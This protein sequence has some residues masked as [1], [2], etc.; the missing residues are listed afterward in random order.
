MR[1][2]RLSLKNWRNFKTV[3]IPIADRLFV[4][5]PNAL[6]KSNLLDA[7][8]FLRDI[9]DTGGDLQHAVTVR[10]GL[11]RVRCLAA[12]NFNH[13]R[14]GLEISLHDPSSDTTWDYELNLTA[15][16][17][18]LHRPVVTSE[19]VREN[20]ETI[21]ERPVSED[22]DDRERLTQTALE[23]VNSNRRFRAVVEFLTG[24]CYLH[25]VP[26]IIRD[27]ESAQNRGSDPFGRDFLVRVAETSERSRESRLEKVNEVLR[28]AV[29][30]IKELRLIRDAAG[31]PHLQ[32]RYQHWRERGALQEER[33]FP[34]GTLRLI[35]L[36]W[37]LQERALRTNRVVLLEEPELSLHTAVVRQLPSMLSRVTRRKGIQ[38][39]LSTHSTEMLADTGLGLNEVV[40]LHPGAEGT[41]ATMASDIDHVQSHLDAGLGLQEILEPHTSP[42]EIDKLSLL[43]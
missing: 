16:S 18:G 8:R 21:L 27:P 15:E 14:V 35:G 4:I 34:D 37:M 23:Q 38:V 32:A 31:T 20:G 11:K 22:A 28:V 26:Q 24:V 17:R 2:T 9:V 25:L 3:D 36:L 19:I 10:G 43:G 42:G 33:D 41:T 7:L 30:Q 13:G 40:V 12:R 5:G 39:I 6:G 1:L 29:P